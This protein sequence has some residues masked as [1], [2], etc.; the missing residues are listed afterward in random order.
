MLASLESQG[1]LRSSNLLRYRPMEVM[2]FEFIWGSAINRELFIAAALGA[3]IGLER[4]LAGKEPSLRTFSLICVGSCIFTIVSQTAVGGWVGGD[5]S[6]IA[7]QIVSGIGFLGAG[8]IFKGGTGVSGITTATLIWTTAAIGM[9]VGFG[10]T[11]LAISGT[12]LSLA[13]II[14]LKIVHA[15]IDVVQARVPFLRPRP[16]PKSPH[17]LE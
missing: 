14:L 13:I 12:I 2:D 15:S 5:P 6:R 3:L 11:D 16:R 9:A 4:D 17:A 10:R 7:A 1:K 8:A